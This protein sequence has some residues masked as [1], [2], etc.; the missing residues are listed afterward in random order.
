M[1]GADALLAFGGQG[2]EEPDLLTLLPLPNDEEVS[3]RN[4]TLI[5][6][7]FYKF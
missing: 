4:N 1:A 2:I 6:E 5:P 7:P 3:G